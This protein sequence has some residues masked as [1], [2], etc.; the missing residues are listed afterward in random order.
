MNR[1]LNPIVAAASAI[2]FA[3]PLTV[4]DFAL[5]QTQTNRQIAVE[6]AAEQKPAAEASEPGKAEAKPETAPVDAAAAKK[7]PAP[8]KKA[9]GVTDDK[10]PADAPVS[11][12]KAEAEKETAPV[13]K[14]A[15]APDDKASSPASAA[16][17]DASDGAP[18]KLS[19][20]DIV[21]AL[22]TELKRV[23]CYYGALDGIWGR[24]SSSALQA[25]GRFGKIKKYDFKPSEVWIKHVTGKKKTVCS[26]NYGYGRP[27]QGYGPR[28]GYGV[29]PQGGYQG[30]YG[31]GNG[32]Y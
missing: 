24:R 15:A 10:K 13:S 16:P 14:A 18:V 30:G 29:P 7:E 27:G 20:K 28:P 22:Q 26:R 19:V 32:R 17:A 3:L 25:F 11:K 31:R 6:P 1:H 9:T 4:A 21:L 2:A 5:G 8:E 12:D 23:G